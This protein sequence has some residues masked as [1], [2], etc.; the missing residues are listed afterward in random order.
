MQDTLIILQKQNSHLSS[1]ENL[2][3]EVEQEKFEKYK[4]NYPGLTE[5]TKCKYKRNKRIT[6]F[7]SWIELERITWSLIKVVYVT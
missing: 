7:F 5:R 2:W 6:K 3:N 1:A 4:F